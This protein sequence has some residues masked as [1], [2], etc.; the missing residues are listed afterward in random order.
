[1]RR[2]KTNGNGF[3]ES[4]PRNSLESSLGFKLGELSKLVMNELSEVSKN[5]DKKTRTLNDVLVHCRKGEGRATVIPCLSHELK[6]ESAIAQGN[7]G[8]KKREGG[9]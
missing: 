7:D 4:S 6:R 5:S 9:K 8:R 2:E 3:L 1:M